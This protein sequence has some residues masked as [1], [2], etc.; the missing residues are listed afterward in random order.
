MPS[1][2][3]KRCV[4]I[5]LTNPKKSTRKMDLY[6]LPADADTQGYSISVVPEVAY[7]LTTC[8]A[9]DLS[10]LECLAMLVGSSLVRYSEGAAT[11]LPDLLLEYMLQ[12]QR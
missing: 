5:P 9:I 10:H 6:I 1:E 8:I 2:V 12:D 3:K 4:A 11:T 7:P